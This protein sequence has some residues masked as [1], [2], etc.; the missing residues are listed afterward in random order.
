MVKLIVL[1]FSLIIIGIILIPEAIKHHKFKKK[2]PNGYPENKWD[3]YPEIDDDLQRWC[4][5]QY[6]DDDRESQRRF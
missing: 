3:N 1:A 2:W 5:L 6:K 4:E